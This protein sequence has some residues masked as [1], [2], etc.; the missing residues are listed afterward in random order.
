MLLR[1]GRRRLRNSG[2]LGLYFPPLL[3]NLLLVHARYVLQHE[4]NLIIT[5]LRILVQI[6]FH[7]FKLMPN[8]APISFR[9]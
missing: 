7:S 4:P 6:V 9:I 5:L 3:A 8:K 1:D 2:A